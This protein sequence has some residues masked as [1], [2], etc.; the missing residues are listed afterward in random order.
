MS[1]HTFFLKKDGVLLKVE[2]SHACLRTFT[3][4]CME[5]ELGWDEK[6]EASVYGALAAAFS[7]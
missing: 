7:P 6:Q 2:E 4:R 5:M 1:S 3:P